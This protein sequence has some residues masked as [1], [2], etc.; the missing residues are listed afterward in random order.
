MVCGGGWGAATIGRVRRLARRGGRNH[1][2][3]TEIVHRAPGCTS[4]GTVWTGP[5]R[6]G[7]PGAALPG[8]RFT[9]G[10]APISQEDA[11]ARSTHSHPDRRRPAVGRPDRIRGVPPAR[12]AADDRLG[13]LR[14]HRGARG[15]RHRADQQVLRGLRRQALL[16]G[17]AVHRPDR[18]AR[19]RTGPR[20]LRGRPR[21]RPAVLRLPREPRRLPG[22]PD[23]GR[24]GDGDGAADGRAPHPRLVG[25]GHRQVVHPGAL[26]RRPGNRP[27]RPRR[28]TRT[29]AARAPQGDLLRR[30]GGPPDHRLPRLRRDRPRGR[31]DP[32]RR[33][34]AH[35]RPDRR[36][37]APVAGRVTPTSSPPPRTRRC[38]ARAAP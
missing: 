37:G 3:A 38:A 8:P 20:A 5:G 36:R 35:R 27:D 16:R 9:A 22:V 26:P 21:Q 33:H 10:Q 28:G 6:T 32:G 18:D 29:G 25:L 1:R 14:L 15:Q 34:R 2:G 4:T 24:Q 11:R 17:S 31:R 19:H 30:H 23:P 12:Q 7:G 13:E